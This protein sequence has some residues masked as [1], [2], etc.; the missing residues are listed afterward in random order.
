MRMD[1]MSK[2]VSTCTLAF[3]Y[4]LTY[5]LVPL[6]QRACS[7]SKYAVTSHPFSKWDKVYIF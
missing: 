7:T 1:V 6:K 4:L 2:R 5:F 3:L